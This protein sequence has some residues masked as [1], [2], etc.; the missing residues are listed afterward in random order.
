MIYIILLI[1]LLACLIVASIE[2]VKENTVYVVEFFGKFSRIMR[3][4]LNLKVPIIEQIEEKV[5]LKQQNFTLTHK[6]HTKNKMVIDLSVNLIFSVISSEEGI[7]RYTYVLVNRE[8]T[9]SATIEDAL[10]VTIG[11]ETEADI[12]RNKET[13]TRGIQKELETQL[14]EWGIK[15]LSF[16]ITS[17]R[18]VPTF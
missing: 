7:R 5:T 13:L 3:P 6:F 8:K 9:I 17:V 14:A 16:Q 4:G 18:S 10:R 11:N 12:L 1:I 2:I 15:I